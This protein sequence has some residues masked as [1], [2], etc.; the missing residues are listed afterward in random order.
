MTIPT[1]E[2]L[3]AMIL[4]GL[5]NIASLPAEKRTAQFMRI[6]SYYPPIVLRLIRERANEFE[7][8][9]LLWI[10]A[11]IELFYELQKPPPPR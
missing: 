1:I 11:G 6:M 4:E 5:I 10:K 2:E 3:D 7:P 9:H 8:V